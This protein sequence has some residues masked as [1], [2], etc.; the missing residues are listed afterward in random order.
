MHD[1]PN[2]VRALVCDIS[3]AERTI[4]YLRV[5]ERGTVTDAGGAL[6]AL[7]LGS[8]RVGAEAASV[9]AALAGA[10]PADETPFCFSALAL[11]SGS[12]ADVHV[13]GDPTGAWVVLVDRTDQV[14]ERRIA[15]QLA[16]DMSLLRA[17]ADRRGAQHASG[18]LEL[19]SRLGIDEAGATRR[20]S[21]L[22][23]QVL[24]Q[25]AADASAEDVVRNVGALLR[26]IERPIV[27]DGGFLHAL[28]AER[29]TAIFGL[30][31]GA[32]PPSI[33][34]VTAAVRVAGVVDEL[35]AVQGERS[36]VTCSF[37]IGIATGDAVF[38]GVGG[39]RPRRI[40][41]W[42]APFAMAEG[43]AAAAL[44]R[45]ILADRETLETLDELPIRV[46]T[47][48]ATD[49]AAGGGRASW[50]TLPLPTPSCPEFCPRST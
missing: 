22:D 10:L 41:A 6:V 23:V 32:T 25:F 17:E 14:H 9:L 20:V 1:L 48:P 49:V 34:A 28:T 5:D 29:T 3:I 44:D 40:L 12:F 24:W 16:N 45:P 2:P 43:L 33:R 30:P 31:A 7:G 36:G 8:V 11:D 18:A 26:G 46:R 38:G 42:G 4:A 50:I 19:A 13:F 47:E 39:L 35:K 37:G 15:Q 21:V 27:D